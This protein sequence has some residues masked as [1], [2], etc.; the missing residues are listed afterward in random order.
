M[1][2]KAIVVDIDGTM[3]NVNHRLHHIHKENKDWNSFHSESENDK[4][5]LWCKELVSAMHLLNYK[6]LFLTGRDDQYFDITKAWLGKHQIP[7]DD[8]FMR[9]NGDFRHDTIIKRELYESF[10]KDTHDV[11]FVIE[12]RA[13]V[14]DMW[15]QLGITCLQCDVGDF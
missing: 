15:R 8:I 5:N 7:F 13:S 3:A 10:I 9:K 11:L 4:I 1:K 12:D 2:S 14:V 6:I